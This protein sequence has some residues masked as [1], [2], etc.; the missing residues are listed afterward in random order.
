MITA[1]KGHNVNRAQNVAFREQNY[2]AV[3]MRSVAEEINFISLAAATGR[4]K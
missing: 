1:S 2:A 4:N 3:E